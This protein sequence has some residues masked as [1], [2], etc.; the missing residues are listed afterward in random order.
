MQHTGGPD[1]LS[2]VIY[3]CVTKITYSSQM[4]NSNFFFRGTVTKRIIII[5]ESQLKKN[6]L[7]S[8]DIFAFV[9]VSIIP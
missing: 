3:T 6:R 5:K 1:P 8:M 2:I 7:T 9:F 4:I